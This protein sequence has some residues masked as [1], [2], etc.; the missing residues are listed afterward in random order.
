MYISRF[1]RL[2]I[3]EFKGRLRTL[4]I[5]LG[6]IKNISFVGARTCAIDVKLDYIG[7]F[8]KRMTE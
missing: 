1:K 2:P 8:C 3:S 7:A 5:F 6:G 4:K